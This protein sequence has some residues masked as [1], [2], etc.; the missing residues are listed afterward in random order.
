MGKKYSKLTDE[1]KAARKAYNK[2]YRE[3][4]REKIK[5]NSRVYY[6]ANKEQ[7]KVRNRR[8]WDINGGHYRGGSFKNFLV[9]ALNVAK[10][11][12][13]TMNRNYD[14]DIQYIM[15]MLEAQNYRCAIT[16][17][18]M[19]HKFHDL[20][21]VSI[22]RIHSTI[23]HVKGNIQLVCQ[24][25][26]L[27]KRDKPNSEAIEFFDEIEKNILDRLRLEQSENTHA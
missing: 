8:N 12:D 15:E 11:R 25:V 14:L 13:I 17:I 24:F 22:D 1:Q 21:A 6:A 27:G 18:R 10:R 4:N 5:A 7:F 2:K 20:R 3:A 26:N 23:G 9:G 16:N 19:T